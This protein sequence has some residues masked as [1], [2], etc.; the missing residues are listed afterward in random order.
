MKKILIVCLCLTLFLSSCSYTHKVDG[1]EN[2]DVNLPEFGVNRGI[3]PNES[4]I[5]EYPYK[6]A[7]Y[8]YRED[9]RNTTLNIVEKSLVA[10]EYEHNDYLKAKEYCVKTMSLTNAEALEYNGYTFLDNQS[11]LSDFPQHFNMVAYND[12]KCELVFLGIYTDKYPSGGTDA[13]EVKANWGEFVE[14]YFGDI[15]DWDNS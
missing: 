6:N 13:E 12:S 9:H 11:V 10:F 14:E 15:Y 3:L 8:H 2:F 4:F 1:I 7:D 5:S